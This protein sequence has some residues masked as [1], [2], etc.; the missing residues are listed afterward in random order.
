MTADA[1]PLRY[2]GTAFHGLIISA[3]L[4]KLF[5]LDIYHDSFEFIYICSLFTCV[6]S[7]L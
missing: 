4:C 2:L 3:A 7:S 1:Y 6:F 5:F